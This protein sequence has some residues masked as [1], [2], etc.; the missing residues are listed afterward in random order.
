M[1]ASGIDPKKIMDASAVATMCSE[2]A[3]EST[4][5]LRRGSLLKDEC[6]CTTRIAIDR[7]HY[8]EKVGERSPQG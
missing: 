6:D 5:Q 4:L 3:Q 2:K 1:S 8:L 7:G